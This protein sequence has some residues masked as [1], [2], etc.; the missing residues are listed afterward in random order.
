[1]ND[2]IIGENSQLGYFLKGTKVSAR[3]IPYDFIL[4]KEWNRIYI[5]FAEQRTFL[6][7]SDSFMKINFNLT[8]EVIEKLYDKCKEFVF[9]S[10]TMLWSGVSGKYS[11]EMPYSYKE[12]DYL[13]SKEKI[14]EHL[15]EIN[16]VSIHYPCN[17]NSKQ[18]KGGFLFSSLY[19][20]I[21][22]KKKN[23]VRC[24][25]F[26]KEIAHAS[27]IANKS[28]NMFGDNI[29]APG[30]S[31]NIRSLFSNIL[32]AFD[33]NIK[34]YIEET[35]ID[36]FIKPNDYYYHKVDDNYPEDELISSFVGELK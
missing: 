13:V 12:S 36:D 26:K 23:Q 34:D 1:M 32:D 19:D 24:L 6:D 7:N 33:M 22:N 17:F 16:K 3:N 4:Q 10:T 20:V 14:T 21:I 18:R 30:Y 5:C 28:T 9:Y 8:K 27:Y 35:H 25:D 29:I 31:I 2:L 11:I 15:K